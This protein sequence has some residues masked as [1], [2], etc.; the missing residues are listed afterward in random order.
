[1]GIESHPKSP[2]IG[3]R[4]FLRRASLAGL[5]VA[6]GV[7]G[8]SWAVQGDQLHIRNYTEITS[9][10]PPHAVSGAEGIIMRAIFQ[11]LLQIKPG[12]TWG[13]E[14]DAAEHFEQIDETHY[15]FRL[16]P[17]QM[18][19][20]G[21]GEMTADDVKFSLERVIDPAIN[22]LN[23]V[24][25]G[26]LSHV[27]VHDRYSGTLVLQSPFAAFLTVG[28]GGMTGAIL[29]R[30]AIESVGGRFTVNPPCCSGPY[31]FEEWHAQ[32]K[33]LLVRNPNWKGPEAAFSEIHIYPLY[34][35][36]AAEL[37]FEAGQLDHSEI[38]V[39]SVEPFRRN[40]PPNSRV[41]VHLAVRN[42]WIGMNSENPA[43]RDIR[44]RRAIQYAID[45]DVVL[46]AGWFGLAE[47]STGPIPKG[48]IGYR[49]QARIPLKGDRDK[50]QALLH[51]AGVSLPMKLTL[52]TA[53]G[54]H[55]LT[56][57]QVVQWSLKKVGIEI[58]I[59]SQDNNSF[60]DLGQESKGDQWKD[61][62][63][64]YQSFNGGADPYYFMVWFTSQQV[65][66]W[67]WERFS[68][69]EFDRLNEEAMATTDDVERARMYR[70]MQGLMEDSGCY[71]F[72]TNEVLPH[73]SRRTVESAI[74]PSGYAHLRG[75]RPA[76]SQT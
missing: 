61:L 22:A 70:R 74:L 56:V 50:A 64:Y 10:D 23:A 16:K 5:A 66:L 30:K 8:I 34:D 69:P 52:N 47:P 1:M 39:E 14:L 73:I 19:S 41:E 15:A 59:K 21:F 67:N 29:P 33:T 28:I 44:V 75:F 43:L 36:K 51:E 54:A 24:D 20:N 11:G 38:S 27:E 65:G 26:T 63:L 55:E 48:M 35:E 45:V 13:V 32:R 3:R 42:A 49:P 2:G 57:A 9:L 25:M 72:I 31:L 71:R 4:D 40:L 53:N 18:Y 12:R 58:D 68:N 60:L 6:G 62:Q 76:G 37:A 17:G 46:Q 7:P